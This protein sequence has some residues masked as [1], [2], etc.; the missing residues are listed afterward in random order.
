LERVFSVRLREVKLHSLFGKG[1]NIGDLHQFPSQQGVF[2]DGK[3]MPG[4]SV[5]EGLNNEEGNAVTLEDVDQDD[6]AEKILFTP[7]RDAD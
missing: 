3:V 1:Q 2:G 4:I 5:P 7:F 6:T